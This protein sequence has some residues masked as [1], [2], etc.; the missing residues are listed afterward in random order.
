MLGWKTVNLLQGEDP[1]YRLL[2]VEKKGKR[3]VALELSVLAHHGGTTWKHM[4]LS[5]K[6]PVQYYLEARSPVVVCLKRNTKL[7]RTGA[8]SRV[9]IKGGIAHGVVRD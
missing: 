3:M 2:L 9:M 5:S 1:R 4:S 8:P 6:K 7:L